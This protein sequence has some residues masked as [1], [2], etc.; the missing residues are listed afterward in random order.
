MDIWF[1]SIIVIVVCIVASIAN[2]VN[3]QAIRTCKQHSWEKF[4][5]NLRCRIYKKFVE[6]TII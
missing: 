5:S 3:G 4:N 6:E 1:I 2:K